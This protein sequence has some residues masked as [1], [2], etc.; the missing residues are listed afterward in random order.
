[1]P[2]KSQEEL[3]L[4]GTHQLL[5]YADYIDWLCKNISVLEKN[6]ER[7]LDSSKEVDLDMVM[8]G[9]QNAGQI[10]NITRVADPL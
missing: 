1:M 4:N 10:G 9:E 5:V 8:G 7:V 3:Q 6:T 2:E